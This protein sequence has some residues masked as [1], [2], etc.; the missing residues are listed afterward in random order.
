MDSDNW[1]DYKKALPYEGSICEVFGSP[2]RCCELDMEDE[3]ILKCIFKIKLTCYKISE[4]N[5]VEDMEF[6]ET[7]EV[8]EKDAEQDFYPKRWM[9]EVVKWRNYVFR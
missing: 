9:I 4:F 5:E 8:I 6:N 7:F 3:Q 1:I 2:T